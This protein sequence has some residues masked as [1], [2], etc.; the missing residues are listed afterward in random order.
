MRRERQHMVL[1]SDGG[2]PAGV[3]TL[4]DLLG[5]IQGLPASTQSNS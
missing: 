3:L 4:H 5:V 2:A 1:V